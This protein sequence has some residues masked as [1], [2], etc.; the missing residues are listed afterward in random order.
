MVAGELGGDCFTELHGPHDLPA[1]ILAL[2][3][4][5]AGDE[6]GIFGIV[7]E[8]TGNREDAAAAPK[9]AGVVVAILM[10]N[11]EPPGAASR[12]GQRPVA[13]ERIVVFGCDQRG[14]WTVWLALDLLG[15]CGARSIHALHPLQVEG[16]R[17]YGL[18]QNPDEILAASDI[19]VLASRREGFP[20]TL[21]EALAAGLPVISVSCNS[22]PAEI[23][24]HEIDGILVPPEN[25][26]ALAAAMD[27]LM[28]SSAERHS[29][30]VRAPEV[31]DRFGSEKVMVEWTKLLLQVTRESRAPATRDSS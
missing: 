11:S 28:S 29:M 27:R 7:E 3:V 5:D 4:I 1:G 25:V 18:V 23:L 15:R 24:R 12:D 20:N 6:K 16:V 30:S 2:H 14:D 21:L 31:R 22:G 10:G 8:N 26:A 9:E 19:F 17:F 13:E